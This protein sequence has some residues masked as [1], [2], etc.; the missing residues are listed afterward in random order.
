MPWHRN[1]P[2]ACWRIWD[3]PNRM[4]TGGRAR[5]Y[6]SR[7]DAGLPLLRRGRWGRQAPSLPLA[8]DERFADEDLARRR[9]VDRGEIDAPVD[10]DDEA[11]HRRPLERDDL[12]G[13]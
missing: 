12:P 4:P 7:R 5:P 10:V 13:L 3:C 1:S 9:R 6:V 11:V 8:G 2:I